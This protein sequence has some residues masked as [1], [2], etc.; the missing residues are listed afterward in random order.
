MA[1]WYQKWFDSPYYHKLYFQRDEAEA[2]AFIQRLLDYLKPAA[3]ARMLDVACGRGRHSKMLATAH[4]DVTGT[5]LSPQSI[6]YAKHFETEQLHFYLH[7]MRLPFWVAYFDYAFNFFTSFGYFAT[8]REHNGAMRAIAQSLKPAGILL[9]DYLNVGYAEAHL[10][11]EEIKKVDSTTYEIQRWQDE[12]H[13]Y[14]RIRVS[15]PELQVPLEF[16]EKVAKFTLDDFTQMLAL[17]K[18][19]IEAVFGSYNLEPY[20]A[21]H[22][23]RLI[24][25]AKRANA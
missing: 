7:D 23:P 15:D 11:T 6:A 10:H 4:F 1:A 13:F 2:Q 5:D 24:V 12:T 18:M 25:V 9:F 19:Q 14:K 20:N 21:Q 16:C 17:Q 22:A 8:Q 3:G